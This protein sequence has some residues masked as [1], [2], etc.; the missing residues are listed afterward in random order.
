MTCVFPDCN[1]PMTGAHIACV[2]HWRSLPP[3]IR[4]EAQARIHGWRN[5]GA[6]RE[7]VLYWL[8]SEKRAGRGMH[9]DTDSDGRG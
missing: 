8:R 3:R 2:D 9:N 7:F 6:A 1:L 4:L 5:I